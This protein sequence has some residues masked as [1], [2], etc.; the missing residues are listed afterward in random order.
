MPSS[1][2]VERRVR[3]MGKVLAGRKKPAAPPPVVR[4]ETRRGA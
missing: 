3:V 4:R 1:K 2:S